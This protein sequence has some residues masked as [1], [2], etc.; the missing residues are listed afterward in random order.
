MTKPKSFD[1]WPT[2]RQAEWKTKQAEY[3]REARAANPEKFKERERKYRAANPERLAANESFLSR[4]PSD[5]IRHPLTGA[6][7]P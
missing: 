2:E 5:G 1:T 4:T 7:F 3:Q 6:A